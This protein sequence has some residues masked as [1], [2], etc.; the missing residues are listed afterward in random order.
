MLVV[1]L[2]TAL[3]P[4]ICFFWVFFLFTDNYKLNTMNSSGFD[5]ELDGCLPDPLREPVI[6]YQHKINGYLFFF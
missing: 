3:F 5:A 1:W 2:I 6:K 4:L